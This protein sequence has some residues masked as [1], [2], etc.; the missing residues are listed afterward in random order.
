MDGPRMDSHGADTRRMRLRTPFPARER[1]YLKPD[2]LAIINTVEDAID[3]F[4]H[5]APVRGRVRLPGRAAGKPGLRVG[6]VSET[7]AVSGRS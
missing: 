1:Q 2:V 5:D 7:R 6:G 4:E 3:E